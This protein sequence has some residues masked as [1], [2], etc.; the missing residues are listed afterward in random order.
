MRSAHMQCSL[1]L[2]WCTGVTIEQI[3]KDTEKSA[4]AAEAVLS[5]QA[6]PGGLA[7]QCRASDPVQ[8]DKQ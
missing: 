7:Q 3:Q 8:A 2:V 5:Q 6:D 1:L 4:A